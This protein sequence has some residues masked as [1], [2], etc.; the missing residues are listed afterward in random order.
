[1]AARSRQLKQL[2]Q[3][4]TGH[5]FWDPNNSR[6]E[7]RRIER[8]LH[9]YRDE[10]GGLLE[11]GLFALANGTNPEILLFVEARVDPKDKSR[12]VWQYAVGRLAHAELHLDYD[13]KEIF[14]APRGG[15]LS[16]RDKPYW[17]DFIPAAPDAGPGK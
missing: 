10:A 7:L 17:V 16:G 6:Y 9:T 15:A 13:G 3:K 1:V 12:A 14:S 11:G 8:P 5:Q 2:A 4:F